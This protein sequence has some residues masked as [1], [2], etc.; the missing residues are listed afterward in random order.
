MTNEKILDWWK[1]RNSLNITSVTY[2]RNTIDWVIH[3]ERDIENICF[4]IRHSDG[5]L[6]VQNI[7]S[8]E[9]IREN[10]ISYIKIPFISTGDEFILKYM[11]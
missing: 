7:N 9:V 2:L 8:Y 1:R 4:K 6:W 5:K 3:A 11:K 10:D